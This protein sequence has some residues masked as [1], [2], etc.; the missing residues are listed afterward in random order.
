MARFDLKNATIKMRDGLAGTGNVDDAA[1]LPDGAT[2]ATIAGT[3][4]NTEFTDVVPVGARFTV[5]GE[6][7]AAGETL[8]TVHVV[9]ATDGVDGTTPSTTI[10]FSPEIEACLLY[11]S[12]SPR[13]RG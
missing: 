5:A 1:G 7:L 8:P 11:T 13:D 9:T 10:T 3:V 4:L 2:T 12:P 6:A